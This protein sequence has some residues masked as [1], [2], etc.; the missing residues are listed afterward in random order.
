MTFGA[1]LWSHRRLTAPDRR[2]TCL[3]LLSEYQVRWVAEIIASSGR[4]GAASKFGI[5]SSSNLREGFA[6]L[7]LFPAPST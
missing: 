3:L 6:V 7:V 2:E 4:S 1:K 5:I